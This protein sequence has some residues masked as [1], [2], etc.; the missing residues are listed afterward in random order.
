MTLH[1]SL[2]VIFTTASMWHAGMAM[3]AQRADDTAS[4]PIRPIRIVVGFTPGGQPDIYARLIAPK[5]AEALHQQVV[6]ENR[7]GAGST[8][9][10]K[11]VVDATPDG[12]TLLSVSSAHL[13]S[14]AVFANLPYDTIRDL[15]AITTTAMA[16]YLL[17]VT[18]SL[19]VATVQEFIALA[20]SKPGQFNFSSAGTGSGTHFAGE[21]FKQSAN[22]DVVHVPYTG[23]PESLTDAIT[24]R[25]QFTMAPV[26]SSVAL[27]KDGKLRAL[28]T[29]SKKRS[30]IYPEIPTIAESGLPGFEWDSW[31]GMLA[32]SKTPR[33]IIN[34]LNREIS[35]I[36][37]LPEIEQRLRTLG[38]Q[39]A[40]SLPAQ[41]DAYIAAQLRVAAQL[42]KK[43]G[44]VGQ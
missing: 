40:P 9:G 27:V 36:L 4:Y 11:I 6:V 44:I 26:A 22:I 3:S 16:T 18:P 5:L 21:M 29:T 30:A 20:K 13:T 34:R 33:A 8:I 31:G 39:P 17:V 43:A 19:G 10:T 35:R 2:A 42:A 12:H 14:P 23:I 24:G 41:T 38:A 25:V 1:R 37:V 28:G 7:P 32:P 15:S